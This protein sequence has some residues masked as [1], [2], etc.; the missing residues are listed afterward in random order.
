MWICH[1]NA[2]LALCYEADHPGTLSVRARRKKDIRAL[3]PTAAIVATPGQDYQFRAYV[4][5]QVAANAIAAEIQAVDY[6]RFK[7]SC[8][9][10]RL[11]DSY[12]STWQ[13]MLGIQERG[14]GGLYNHR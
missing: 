13:A 11:H 9:D 6:R 5:K 14:T 1:K 10:K 8:T 12:M 4:D 7:P 3:F 2:F